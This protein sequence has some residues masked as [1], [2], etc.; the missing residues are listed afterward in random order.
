MTLAGVTDEV[1]GGVHRAIAVLTALGDQAALGR[2]GVGVVELARLVGCEKS[3]ASRTLKTLA[4]TGLVERDPD[5]LAYR[6]GWRLFSLA[7]VSADERLLALAPPV[8]R[9]VVAVIGERAHL[10]VREGGQ[11]LTIASESSARAVEGAGWVGRTS[12][13]HTTS[14]GRALLLDHADAEVREL[15]ADVAFEPGAGNAPR[16]VEDLLERLRGART[17]GYATTDEE[18]EAG[19]VGVAA[20]V[21]DFRGHVVA[22]L[23]VS[24][25]KYRLGRH[26]A[27]A[28]RQLAVAADALSRELSGAPARPR[29]RS[30]RSS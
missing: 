18:F 16:D 2:S 10:S 23:N 26:L 29:P 11:V 24:A 20:P 3:Q 28:G 9:R 21:R 14:A 13:L 30:R 15:F 22:A 25:P 8:L 1:A 6:L 17:A 27:A 4:G 7:A 5:T 19:L 12:P